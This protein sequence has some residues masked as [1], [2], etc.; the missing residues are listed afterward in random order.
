MFDFY[1]ANSEFGSVLSQAAQVW[2]AIYETDLNLMDRFLLYVSEFGSGQGS[3]G[4]T[5]GETTETIRKS[6]CSTLPQLRDHNN[7]SF[8]REYK[9]RWAAMFPYYYDQKREQLFYL[10]LHLLFL[11]NIIGAYLDNATFSYI[12]YVLRS[13][14]LAIILSAIVYLLIVLTH[15]FRLLLSSFMFASLKIRSFCND[16][17][18]NHIHV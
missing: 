15:V 1:Y 7:R 16:G 18:L 14:P 12:I 17:N 5:A 4:T 9:M 3:S 10:F 2:D 6:T 13:F 11:L 8:R